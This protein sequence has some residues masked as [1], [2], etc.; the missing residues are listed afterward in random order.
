[1]SGKVSKSSA[2]LTAAGAGLGSRILSLGQ[3][4]SVEPAGSRPGSTGV[5]FQRA[6]VNLNGRERGSR[7]ARVEWGR[8]NQGR[9]NHAEGSFS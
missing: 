2:T 4:R 6:R 7:G 5:R 8:V 1:M 9:S 3:E